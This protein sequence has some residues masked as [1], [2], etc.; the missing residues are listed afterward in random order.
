MFGNRCE[1]LLAIHKKHG[2]PNVRFERPEERTDTVPLTV[3]GPTEEAVSK[4]KYEIS[5]IVGAFAS[6]YRM[7][8]QTK[9]KVP[10]YV[11]LSEEELP[12]YPNVSRFVEICERIRERYDVIRECAALVE[13]PQVIIFANI[14][15]VKILEDEKRISWL[16]DVEPLQVQ[17]THQHLEHSER[18]GRLEAFK[19]GFP[20]LKRGGDPS[21][22]ASWSQPTSSRTSR[23]NKMLSRTPTC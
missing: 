3:T 21:R 17:H 7:P 9:L 20:M 18:V 1:R 10:K 19:Q 14:D 12:T 16:F 5:V 2:T 13:A 8:H 4:A 22:P 11:K 23:A 15:N 6:P